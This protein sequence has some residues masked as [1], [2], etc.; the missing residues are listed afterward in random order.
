[1]TAPE[2]ERQ[3]PDALLAEVERERAGGLKVFLGAAPGVGKTYKMIETAQEARR[4]DVDI[5]IGVVESHGREET[6]VLCEGLE[7]IPLL[8]LEHRG[9]RFTEMDLDGILRRAPAVV[10]V[11][12]LAH[13][14]IPGTRHPRRYQDIEELLSRGIDV[15]TTVNI[16]HLESLNDVVARITGVRM[17]ETVPDA[18]LTDARDLVLVDLTPG[19]LVERLRQGKVYVPEQVRA[20]LDGFF[21]TSN[22][23]ALRELALRTVAERIDQ[24]VREARRRRGISGPWPVRSRIVVAVDGLGNSEDVVRLGRRLARRREAPWSAVFVDPGGLDP[25]RL[26]RVERVFELAERL[27]G[28]R[29]TLYGHDPVAELLAYARANNATTLVVGRSRRRPWAGLLGRT[30][31]QRLLREGDDFEITFLASPA[32]RSE[33]R[34]RAGEWTEGILRDYLV[35]TL[36][37]AI[38]VG[39]ALAAEPLLPLASRSLILLTG[40]LIVAVRTA[41]GPALYAAFLAAAAYNFFL[42]YPRYSFALSERDALLTVAFFLIMALIGGRLA[43]RLRQQVRAL[44]KTNEQTR[45]LLALSKRLTTAPDLASVRTEATEAIAEDLGVPVV[46]L[47]PEDAGTMLHRVATAGRE[48]TFDYQGPG[49]RPMGLRSP[50]AERLPYRDPARSGLA[51]PPACGRAGCLRGIRP[52]PGRFGDAD[53]GAARRNRRPSQPGYTRPCQGAAGG[54]PGASQGVR[55]DGAAALRARLLCLIRS[56]HPLGLAARGGEPP[57]GRGQGSVDPGA[58]AARGRRAEPE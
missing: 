1:M 38:A 15:W 17:R 25:D 37:I 49:S 26:S 23:A 51:I 16:Q 14:N 28:E 40:V 13:R 27:G 35:G 36:V 11:D 31:S 47:A 3:D 7:R 39:I 2:S 54:G 32:A 57:A 55:R 9:R 20:A 42:T 33:R 6:E 4:E 10:L 22:L 8:A 41:M 18:L 48:V 58:G 44:R 46:C 29:V 21:S 43:G 5:V 52:A 53:H 12:E 56:A 34:R 30:L 19:E 24:D 45:T 50:P